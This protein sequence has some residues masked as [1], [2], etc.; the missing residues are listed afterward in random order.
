MRSIAALAV[1]TSLIFG[2]GCDT[3]STAQ[4]ASQSENHS[5]ASAPAP[6][7]N[8]SS[9]SPAAPQSAKSYTTVGPLVAVQ[10]ADIAAQ[11]DGRIVSIAVEIGDHVEKGQVL[12]LLDDSMLR[13]SCDA[14]KA[15]VASL[16]A[17]VLDWQAE[18]KSEHNHIELF[19]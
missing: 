9:T 17:Q 11:R 3:S 10:Q 6:H 13:A 16:Q 1:T 18:Q 8:L 4:V 14:Q 12:A 2:S 15:R 7:A 5:S 19:P